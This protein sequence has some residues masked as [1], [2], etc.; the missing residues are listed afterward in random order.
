M[1]R[2]QVHAPNT[3]YSY[4]FHTTRILSR[5]SCTLGAFYWEPVQNN[6]NVRS[7]AHLDGPTLLF[8][9]TPKLRR[10]SGAERALDKRE[11]ARTS[12]SLGQEAFSQQAYHNEIY[13]LSPSFKVRTIMGFGQILLSSFIAATI[14]VHAWQKAPLSEVPLLLTITITSTPLT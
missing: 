1:G 11:S 4:S 12:G 6:E 8:D 7:L 14:F 9:C 3:I 2:V 10:N 5:E 13:E